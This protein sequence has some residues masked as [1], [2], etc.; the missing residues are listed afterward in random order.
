MKDRHGQYFQLTEYFSSRQHNGD[1]HNHYGDRKPLRA[2]P[3]DKSYERGL[4]QAAHTGAVK[5]IRRYL[6]FD[7]DVNHVDEQGCTALDYS[8]RTG[9]FEISEHLIEAGANVDA[10]T[11]AA[12]T[13]LCEAIMAGK[14][15]KAKLLLDSGAD[16]NFRCMWY[17]SA[18]HAAC[19][20]GSVEAVELIMG[21]AADSHAS[22]T[23]LWWDNDTG[24]HVRVACTP[25]YT[26]V[27][28]GH[29]ALVQKMI[30]TG[31]SVDE[32][33]VAAL[34]DFQNTQAR[35]QDL[36]NSS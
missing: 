7:V 19:S 30:G 22:C 14:L 33:S 1:V 21:S 11:H 31:D 32:T 5:R 27:Q 2:P 17:G 12:G 36:E 4:V 20:T 34:H 28:Y 6:T 8:A 26:A 3:S 25:L 35:P 16:V 15:E 18:I 13:P 9:N 23:K 29:S 24:Q 10:R